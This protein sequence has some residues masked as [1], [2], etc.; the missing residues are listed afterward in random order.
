VGGGFIYPEAE[1]R[2]NLVKDIDVISDVAEAAGSFGLVGSDKVQERGTEGLL[3]EAVCSVG[4]LRF[5]VLSRPDA[6]GTTA[7]KLRA[8]EPLVLGTSYPVIMQGV[9]GDAAKLGL[10]RAGSVESLP[11]RFFWLD[12]VFEAVSS[13]D[14]ARDNELVVVVDNLASVDLMLLC[15]ATAAA[16]LPANPMSKV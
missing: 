1:R 4:G 7:A 2:W 9:L 12:G 16:G 11:W 3:A 8:G 15:Q 14:S 6:A 13:G 5:A 10:V